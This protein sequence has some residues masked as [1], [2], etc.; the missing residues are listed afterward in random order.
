MILHFSTIQKEYVVYWMLRILREMILETTNSQIAKIKT[1]RNHPLKYKYLIL[2]HNIQLPMPFP[3]CEC[4]TSIL[5][6]IVFEEY[7]Q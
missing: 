4:V 1:F 6:I 2:L 3:S 7:Q 5:P